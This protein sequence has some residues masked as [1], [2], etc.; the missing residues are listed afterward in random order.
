MSGWAP[1]RFWQK[2]EAMA[3]AGGFTVHLDAK[4]VRTP[5]KAEFVLPTM[6]LAEAV[7]LE[8]E[9]QDGQVR[10]ET[11]PN[12]RSANSAIDKIVPQFPE[13]VDLVAAYGASDLLCYR[14]TTPDALIRLQHNGWQPLLDWAADALGAPLSVT[15]GVIPVPQPEASLSVLHTRVRALSPFQLVAFHDLVAISGSLILG[16]AVAEGRV[17]VAEAWD[18]SRIDED[19]QAREWGVD[20]DAAATA[21]LKRAA[22]EHAGRF[23]GLCG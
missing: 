19:W 4:P 17:G 8:W 6:G 16:F 3:C 23:F 2:A 18:L 12:T 22:M 1:K 7:A 10:P 13:V 14:A 20:D 9:A 15:Q 5:A 21:A 11:M